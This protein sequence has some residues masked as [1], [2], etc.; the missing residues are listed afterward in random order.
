MRKLIAT[1]GYSQFVVTKYPE[2]DMYISSRKYQKREISG[3]SWE[4]VSRFKK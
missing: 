1:L 4:W 2:S 3:G